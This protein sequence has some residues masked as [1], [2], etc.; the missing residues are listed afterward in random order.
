[1]TVSFDKG[2]ASTGEESYTEWNE[3]WEKLKKIL[4]V[5]QKNNKQ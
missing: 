3:E 2:S 4:T 1:M 5:G